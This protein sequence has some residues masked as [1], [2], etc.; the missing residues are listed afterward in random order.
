[1]VLKKI[2]PKSQYMRPKVQNLDD[3]PIEMH[4]MK[5]TK[6]SKSKHT[7]VKLKP[8]RITSVKSSKS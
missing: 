2:R 7:D 8:T 3:R 6:T 1:M 5:T 4:S